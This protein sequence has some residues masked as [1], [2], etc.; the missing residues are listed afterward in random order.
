MKGHFP[1]TFKSQLEKK[2]KNV[3]HRPGSVRIVKN[4]AL[5]LSTARG[6]TQDLGHSFSQYGSEFL[7]SKNICIFKTW[8]SYSRDWNLNSRFNR[9]RD[10]GFLNLNSGFQSAGYRSPNPTIPNC[11]NKIIPYCGTRTAHWI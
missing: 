6:R 5:V 1:E 11:T 9:Y 8:I 2:N 10:F 7:A 3:I 4:C